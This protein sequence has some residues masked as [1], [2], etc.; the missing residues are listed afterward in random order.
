MLVQTPMELSGVMFKMHIP[1]FHSR[2]EESDY[3]CQV[4]VGWEFF[5]ILKCANLWREVDASPC[6]TFCNTK[7]SPSP[8]IT[9]VTVMQCRD[10]QVFS[11]WSQVKYFLGFVGQEIGFCVGSWMMGKRNSWE[12]FLRQQSLARNLKVCRGVNLDGVSQYIFLRKI[13]SRN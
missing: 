8:S 11:V 4:W 12:I 7:H 6:H 3:C 13:L 9:S 10:Q 2:A 1:G 5:C